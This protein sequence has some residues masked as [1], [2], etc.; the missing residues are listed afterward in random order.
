VLTKLRL[1]EPLDEGGARTLPALGRYRN[2]REP[3]APQ[4]EPAAGL[5]A[6]PGDEETDVTQS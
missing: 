6:L 2:V 3:I 1:V 4:Q 5:F